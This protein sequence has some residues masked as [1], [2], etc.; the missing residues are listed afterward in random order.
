PRAYDPARARTLLQQAGAS[1]LQLTITEIGGFT[2]PGSSALYAE[3]LSRV[4]VQATVKTLTFAQYAANVSSIVANAQMFALQGGNQPFAQSGSIFMLSTSA[5]NFWGW[6][7]P[8]WDAG[9]KKA[10]AIFN[11]KKRNAAYAALQKQ[12]YDQGGM[13]TWGFNPVI[14]GQRPMLHQVLE[15]GYGYPHTPDF[16]QAWLSA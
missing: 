7:H 12:F 14:N 9:F 16:S 6:L 10:Q 11:R 8:D 2:A 1:N 15:A 5:L 3:Q 4:G 13:V